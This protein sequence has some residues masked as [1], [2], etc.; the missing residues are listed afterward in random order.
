LFLPKSAE[1]E[2]RVRYTG[3]PKFNRFFWQSDT[4]EAGTFGSKSFRAPHSTMAV[5]VGLDHGHHI[6]VLADSFTD[7]MKVGSERIQINLG[8]GR[9]SRSGRDVVCG[10]C[11]QE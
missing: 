5:R 7:D 6:H 1:A 4:E 3:R 10:N 11:H 2:Y 9:A 8:P